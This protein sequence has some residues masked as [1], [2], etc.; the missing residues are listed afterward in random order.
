[1]LTVIRRYSIDPA[2]MPKLRQ[3]GQQAAD[4]IGAIP[5]C[6]GYQ[7]VASGEGTVV[8]I[9]LCDDAAAA[10]RTNEAARSWVGA[11][12]PGAAKGP[13]EVISGDLIAKA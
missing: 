12:L 9:T 13:P 10:E 7:L 1:M 3:I 5:G 6:R 8:S 11:N 4:I 2:A